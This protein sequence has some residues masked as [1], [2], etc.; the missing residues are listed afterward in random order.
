MSR[1]DD[2]QLAT[3]HVARGLNQITEGKRSHALPLLSEANPSIRRARC[4]DVSGLDL[5]R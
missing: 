2:D 5:G 4:I 1:D 3:E